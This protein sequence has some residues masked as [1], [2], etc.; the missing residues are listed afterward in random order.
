MRNSRVRVGVGKHSVTI[1][2]L[3]KCSSVSVVDPKPAF[4]PDA[5]P[6]PDPGRKKQIRILVRLLGH[7]KKKNFYM[8]NIL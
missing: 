3:L 1:M 6:D 2:D 4:Y 7:E 8:K 5:D